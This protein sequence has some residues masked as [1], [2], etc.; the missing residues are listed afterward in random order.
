MKRGL[1]CLVA[2]VALCAPAFAQ[3]APMATAKRA[4][5][6][7]TTVAPI[8]VS[9]PPGPTLGPIRTAAVGTVL[10]VLGEKGDWLQVEFNDPQYGARVGWLQK[11][12]V[13]IEDPALKPMDLSVA[14]E[15]VK[16]PEPTPARTSQFAQ[17][18]DEP[19]RR[20]FTILVNLGVGIQHDEFFGD[21]AVGFGGANLGIGGFLTKDLALMFRF[22]GTN[23]TY[24]QGLFGNFGQ[25]SGV[26]GGTVQYWAS[27][28]FSLEGG[29]GL[30]FWND[31]F[32]FS[33]PALGLIFGAAG[34]VFNR[35]K[36][37]LVVGGE[38]APAFTEG[39][40]V[41]NLCFT[42][43]YQYGPRVRR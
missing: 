43:G 26:V 30:G 41:H 28:R 19:E 25:V 21:S 6:T 5:A 27:D 34:T 42:F 17:A 13:K 18:K 20:G 35:G 32:E 8:Y 29:L 10:F 40:T 12:L 1:L 39:G 9:A 36:H 3:V 4:T 2:S 22:S 37:N 7:V 14:A 31:E 38:Y 15:R 23:V 16:P 33:D 11:K 24:D